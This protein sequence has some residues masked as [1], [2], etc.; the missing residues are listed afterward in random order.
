MHFNCRED[1]MQLTPLWTGDRSADGRPHVSADLLRR[2]QHVTTEEAWSICVREGYHY[3]FE[4][5]WVNLHPERILVGRA[6]TGVFVPKRPD[7]HEC[8]MKHGHEQE[9]RVGEM[10]SWVIQTL[11]QDDVIVIDLFGKIR[12]GTY[13]GG[14]LSTAIAARSRRGQVI[15]GGIRDL[16]QI[17]G[18]PDFCTFCRGNDPTGIGDVTLVGLNVP[19][20]IGGA[21]CLPGDVVLGTPAGV[22]FVP[23]HLA[24]EVVAHSEQMRLRE[25]FGFTRLR[26][27]VYTSS[28]MDTKWTEAIEADYAGWLAQRTPQEMDRILWSKSK[29]G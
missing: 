22:I 25:V 23:A 20:R 5:N 26:E 12:N 15:Y 3:Q 18:I 13:S 1:I 8:L 4:G 29:Q 14:N 17:L 10:N 16:Q 7:L 2:M 6:V 9:G 27:G 19:C 28:Q 21:V 24:Q 11:V